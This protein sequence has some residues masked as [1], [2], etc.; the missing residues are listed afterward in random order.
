MKN[1]KNIIDYYNYM[2]NNYNQ[3]LYTKNVNASTLYDVYNGLVRGNMYPNLYNPYKEKQPYEIRPMNDQARL[4]TLVDSYCF[5]IIDIGLYLDLYP[6]DRDMIALYAQYQDELKK[7]TMEYENKYGP[8]K[9]SS[10]TLNEY[11]W[12][13][14]DNPWP[15]EN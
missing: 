12:K 9:L 6:N 14:I 11:P 5:A 13:W 3:P 4:L 2:N 1:F 15:W 8:L 7:A 10:Q